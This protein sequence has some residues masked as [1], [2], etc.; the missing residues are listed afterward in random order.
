[1]A[2]AKGVS[3]TQ[4][5]LTLRGPGSPS[6]KWKRRSNGRSCA[7]SLLRLSHPGSLP[8]VRRV[9]L[10]LYGSYHGKP[11]AGDFKGRAEFLR[12][13][14]EDKGAPRVVMHQCGALHRVLHP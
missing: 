2:P 5:L 8:H 13:L 11:P 1:M 14:L 12:L 4:C 7:C 6:K 9:V 10:P 3:L